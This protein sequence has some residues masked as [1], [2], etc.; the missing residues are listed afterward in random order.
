MTSLRDIQQLLRTQGGRNLRGW[1]TW[2]GFDYN[3]VYRTLKRSTERGYPPSEGTE[4]LRIIR[5]LSRDIGVSIFNN[6]E[7]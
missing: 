4:G 7:H 5:Q 1:S 2:R 6:I 3:L